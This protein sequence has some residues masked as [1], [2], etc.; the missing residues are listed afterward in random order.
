MPE[1]GNN[2]RNK[3]QP[4]RLFVACYVL[5]DTCYDMPLPAKKVPM[6]EIERIKN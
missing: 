2:F 4:I 5:R 6:K 3:K 1:N